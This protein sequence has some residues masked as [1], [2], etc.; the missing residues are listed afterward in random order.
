[1]NLSGSNGQLFLADS[2]TGI[3]PDGAGNIAITDERVIDF[4]GFGSAAIHEGA[5]PAPAS[6][7]NAA[8]LSRDT[9]GADTDDNGADF[10]SD[11]HTSE[12]QSLMR[13]SYAVFCL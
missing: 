9:A 4:V 8:S 10:G 1:M 6:G 3:D 12:L 2:L 13:I 7:S 11:E 5:N